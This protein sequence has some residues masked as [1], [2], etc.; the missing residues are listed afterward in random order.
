MHIEIWY[1][2]V[3][4][5]TY[6]KLNGEMVKEEDIYGF[7]YP[8]RKYLLQAWLPPTGSWPGLAKQIT[9]ISRGEE[10]DILFYGRETDYTDLKAT[11]PG[12]YKTLTFCEWDTLSLWR[13]RLQEAKDEFNKA[14]KDQR[15]E[16]TASGNLRQTIELFPEAVKQINSVTSAD[17]QETWLVNIDNDIQL[18]EAM[19]EKGTC[20]MVS[21]TFLSSFP[22]LEQL[23]LL[24]R[25]VR[26]SADMICCVLNDE[27]TREIFKKYAAQFPHM[28][29]RFCTDEAWER[30]RQSLWEKYG[31]PYEMGQRIRRY[32]IL[33]EDMRGLSIKATELDRQLKEVQARISNGDFSARSVEEVLRKKVN[34]LSDESDTMRQ[35]KENLSSVFGTA[36]LEENGQQL[37]G[38]VTVL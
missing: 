14:I 30:E 37:N 21:S 22:Q 9:E 16:K 5:A 19:W 33:A 18:Q 7:L 34:W 32:L 26:R 28:R 36:L 3:M 1:D 35:L 31:F 20:C 24:T 17:F 27:N 38:E 15:V 12:I 13:T 11:A 4:P 29:Y 6:I 2:P 23:E 8:V 10:T 25:S